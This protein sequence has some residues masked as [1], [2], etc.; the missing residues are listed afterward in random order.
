MTYPSWQGNL[1]QMVEPGQVLR[2]TLILTNAFVAAD[3]I[4]CSGFNK[5][6]ITFTYDRGAVNGAFDWYLDGSIYGVDA[7]AAA[8]AEVWGP[9]SLFA[10]GAVAAGVLSQNRVQ[11][12]YETYQEQG[13]ATES[14]S[15]GTIEISGLD[16]LRLTVQESGVPGTPGTLQAQ[17][18][19]R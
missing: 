1:G 10:A 19:M 11:L 5:V 15:Y 13:A 4:F 9:E 6:T 3:P 16:R 12:G 14:F 2:A 8:G 18:G 7:N 17:V